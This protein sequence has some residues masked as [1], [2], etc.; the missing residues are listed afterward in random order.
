MLQNCVYRSGFIEIVIVSYSYRSCLM[1]IVIASYCC[2][3]KGTVSLSL[4]TATPGF[5]SSGVNLTGHTRLRA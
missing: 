4:L 1:G 5:P 2:R 3:S